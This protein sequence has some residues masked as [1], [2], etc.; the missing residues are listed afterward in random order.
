MTAASS[1][2]APPTSG[3]SSRRVGGLALISLVRIVA[4]ARPHRG[5]HLHRRHRWPCRRSCSRP[6][7]VSTPSGSAWSTSASE[8]M[9]ILGTW[10]A[11]WAGWQWGPWA[12][13]VGGAVGG[14]RRAAAGAGH[15]HLQRRPHR[16]RHRHQPAGARRHPLPVEPGLRGRATAASR[17]SPSH[18]RI[19]RAVHVPVPGRGA[20]LRLADP[21]VLVAGRKRWFF[22]SDAAGLGRASRPAWP[23]RRSSPGSWCRSRPT[24]CGARRSASGSGRSARSRRP[25]T[26]SASPSTGSS[27]SASPSRHALAGLGG[28]WL[29]ID[30]RA[31]NQDQAGRTRLPGPGA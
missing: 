1:T 29:A 10:C 22:I 19:D 14:A 13:L 27:T 4:D 3:R 28:A 11:G 25:P 6:S 5:R 31:Y 9:M 30:I 15:R 8:G 21:D 7:A 20:P 12:A 24:S 23:S 2:T 17:R 26:R 16:G 18:V